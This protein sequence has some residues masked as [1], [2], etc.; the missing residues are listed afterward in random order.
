MCM[1]VCAQIWDVLSNK[2]AVDVVAS[3]PT[4]S[5]AAR[6][7]VDTAIRAWWLKFPTSKID[8]C[9]VVCL[10]LNPPSPS[11]QSQLIESEKNSLGPALQERPGGDHPVE[12]IAAT[13]Q[14]EPPAAHP[15]SSREIEI[16]P[17]AEPLEKS[18]EQQHHQQQSRRLADCLSTTD[19]EEWSAL[20]GV[21][22]VNSLVN[23][24]RFLAGDKR[25]ASWRKWL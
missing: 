21:T 7:L 5:T 25:S 17:A 11:H 12:P 23:L 13:W 9:A 2:E 24:P 8:D 20:E 16:M 22:R 6:A 14:P 3:A 10:F 15:V 18:L 4:R 19:E 1:D